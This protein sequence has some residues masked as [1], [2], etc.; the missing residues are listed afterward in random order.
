MTTEKTASVK[1]AKTSIA[2]TR[3]IAF[4]GVFGAIAAVLMLFEIPLPFAPAFYKLDLSELPVLIGSF[5]FG[6]V[7]GAVIELVKIL[8]KML[9]KGSSTAGVGELANFIVGCSL[10]VPA[11][12]LY[13]KMKTRNGAILGM[14]AGTVIMTILG[15]FINAFV[16]L[17]FY[18]NAFEM[19]IDALIGMG[20]AVNASITDLFSFVMLAVAPF[21]LLKGIVV[22]VLTFLL[23]KRISR[24]VKSAED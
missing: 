15:C 21:N 2:A 24:L 5:C 22:S 19:P 4:C 6:P 3:R 7:A 16:L 13:S 10:V 12:F 1:P 14:A 8:L 11:G 20:T 9:I 17:P 23:Y 18:A